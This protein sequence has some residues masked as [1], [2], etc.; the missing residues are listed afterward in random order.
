MKI[1]IT[2]CAG[3]IGFHTSQRFLKEK[4]QVFGI[5]NINNYYDTSLKKNRI[6][7]LK[8]NKKFTF[9]K[10]DLKNKTNLKELFLKNN[11]KYVVHLAA[12]AGVRYSLSNPQS[13]VQ[14]N[15]LGFS[16]L[17]ELVRDFKPKNFVF[18]S[19]SSVYGSNTNRPSNEADNC[20]QAISL[21]A[22]T[23]RSNE[24][25]AH[26]YADMYKLKCT[27]LRFFTVFGPWGRPDMALFKFTE[28]I[29]KNKYMEVFNNGNHSRDF[30]YIDDV[31]EGIYLST[32]RFEN[33]KNKTKNFTI[34]NIA[35]GKPIKLINFIRTIEKVLN[36]KGK[37][38]YLPMQPG[39]IADTFGDISKI[40]R[41]L[42]YKPKIS[43]VDGVKK[44][45]DWYN[46][47]Y[48]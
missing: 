12:Q 48:K 36:K 13:Y 44:F 11:F 24:E 25:V 22:A 2:G 30:T 4:Y 45:I 32:L 8:K 47:F 27:G 15:L 33:F 10:L 46:F 1:L 3:F 16:N 29:K 5:D 14:S 41:E 26:S 7:I 31:V 37:I 23:K 21:Y 20:N 19:S 43:Y 34:Y 9:I 28:S 17:I 18:A 39:D 35:S 38:K 6:N 42:G 40:K